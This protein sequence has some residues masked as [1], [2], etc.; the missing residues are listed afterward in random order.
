MAFVSGLFIVLMRSRGVGSIPVSSLASL[1]NPDSLEP[2]LRP[3]HAALPLDDKALVDDLNPKLAKLTDNIPK[4]LNISSITSESFVLKWTFNPALNDPSTPS[5]LNGF[6][7][8]YAHNNF[9][10]VKTVTPNEVKYSGDQNFQY[11]YDLKGLSKC[12]I[13]S[14]F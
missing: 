10:S 6:K 3:V 8:Y 7:I 5:Q 12:Q 9:N 1:K 13:M 14:N 4:I 11:E 2:G